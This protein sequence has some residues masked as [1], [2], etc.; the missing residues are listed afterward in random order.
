MISICVLYS[1][2]LYILYS[3]IS[4]VIFTSLC[5]SPPSYHYLT[6]CIIFKFYFRGYSGAGFLSHVVTDILDWRILYGI[7]GGCLWIRFLFS[8][9]GFRPL[10]NNSTTHA[11]TIMTIKNVFRH[12][13][14]SPMGHDLSS[15]ESLL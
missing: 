10:D 3:W 11:P 4:Y 1:F 9:H 13:H 2:F 14:I 7:G 12:C 5:N 15:W 6:T 8:I